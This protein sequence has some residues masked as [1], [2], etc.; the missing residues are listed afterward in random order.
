LIDEKAVEESIIAHLKEVYKDLKD[1]TVDD[2]K[3]KFPKLVDENGTFVGAVN[4]N[5]MEGGNFRTKWNLRVPY[6]DIEGIFGRTILSTIYESIYTF[7]NGRPCESFAQTHT[8]FQ[9]EDVM[10]W[11]PPSRNCES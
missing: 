1:N 9:Y 5:A 6:K 3:E 10:N 8:T 2:L 11:D 4:T 7:R